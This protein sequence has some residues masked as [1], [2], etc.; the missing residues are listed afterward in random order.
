MTSRHALTGVLTLLLLA[1]ACATG[2]QK[3]RYRADELTRA[4][5]MSVDVGNLYDVVNR[6]RPRWLTAERRAGDRSFGLGTGVV[7]YQGQTF[8]G[9]VDVLRQWSPSSAYG[10]KWMDGATASASLPGLGASHVVGAII[11]DTSAPQ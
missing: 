1:T 7:V 6:L 11:I 8:L 3:T 5:I 4:E 10:L 2:G 9:D